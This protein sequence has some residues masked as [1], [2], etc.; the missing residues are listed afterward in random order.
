MSTTTIY[1]EDST[2]E[3]WKCILTDLGLPP[4]TDEIIV[5]HISHITELDRKNKSKK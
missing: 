5:K 3:S 2:E 1:K 4:D